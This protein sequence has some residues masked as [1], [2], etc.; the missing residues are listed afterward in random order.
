MFL[1]AEFA[2]PV[3]QI[4][5]DATASDR[6]AGIIGVG[7]GEALERAEVGLDQIEPRGFGR[8]PHRMD[9]KPL[10]QREEAWVAWTWRR[11][12]MIT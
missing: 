7:Q 10:E 6:V 2:M 4:A 12:S 3:A 8:G 11:L 1:S 9:A 5:V